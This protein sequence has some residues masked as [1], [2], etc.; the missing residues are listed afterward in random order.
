MPSDIADPASKVESPPNIETLEPPARIGVIGTGAFGRFCV[1]AYRQTD[2]LQVVAAADPD[3]LALHFP[4]DEGIRLHSDWRYVVDDPEIEIIHLAAPPH[5]RREVVFASLESGKSV[6]CEKPLALSLID[7]DAIIAAARR[8]GVALG[9]DYVMRHHP[10]YRILETLATS[11]LF[12]RLRTASLQNFAQHMPKDHWFWDRSRSGGILVEHGVHFFD[13]YRRVAG[14]AERVWGL[15]PR[16]E[17]VEVTVG[18]AS[19][20]VGRFYHEFAFPLAVERAEGTFFFEQGSVHVDGWIPTAMQVSVLAEQSALKAVLEGHK[21]HTSC[22]E[23]GDA[24]TTIRFLSRQA[25]YA[26]A[27]VEGIRDTLAQHRDPTHRMRVNE[28]DARESLVLALAAQEA[29]DTGMAVEVE[30]YR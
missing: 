3:P 8:S 23:T 19:G 24:L 27:I 11:G 4:E 6:F 17:A 5:V 22:G 28:E 9:I 2:D 1:D 21:A 30:P 20:A 13:A 7:A 18:Y 15:A 12:G 16:F 10:A 29:I 26:Q 14:E 25:A